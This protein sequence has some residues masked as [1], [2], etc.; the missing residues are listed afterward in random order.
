MRELISHLRI[1][2]S[3]CACYYFV[4]GC[5][6][7]VSMSTVQLHGDEEA[8]ECWDD[9]GDLQIDDAQICTV[10]TASSVANSSLRPSGHRDSISSRRSAR[11]E[12]DSITGT[13]DDWHVMLH[14]DDKFAAEEVLTSARNAGVPIPENVPKS[15]LTGGTIKRLGRR[16]ITD[17]VHD[18]AEDLVFPEKK[19]EL[20]ASEGRT[21]PDAF[22]DAF[23]DLPPSANSSEKARP[24]VDGDGDGGRPPK[25]L[26]TLDRFREDADESLQDVPTIKGAKSA[27][28]SKF[29]AVSSSAAGILPP[30]IGDDLDGFD[31]DFELP[32]DGIPLQLA[33]TKEV[34]ENHN[35]GAE[36]RA[37]ELEMEY[38]EGSIGVSFGGTARDR[39]SIPSSSISVFSP[40]TSSCITGESEDDG[41]DGLIIPDA[42]L[43][44]E[45]SLKKRQGNGFAE[46]EPQPLTPPP[47]ER[48][49]S[50]EPLAEGGDF[51]SG[52]EIG[53]MG[54][55][56]PGKL[57]VNPNVKC[58]TERRSGPSHRPSASIIF[59]DSSKMRAPRQSG[60]DRSHGTQLETVAEGGAPMSSF[61][62]PG[63]R[64]GTQSS[65]SSTSH[66]SA[67]ATTIAPAQHFRQQGMGTGEDRD[68]NAPGGVQP[69]NPRRSIPMLRNVNQLSSTPSSPRQLPPAQTSPARPKTQGDR[70]GNESALGRRSR[71]PPAA[72]IPAGPSW[73]QA[74]QH[75]NV[76]AYHS[77]RTNSDGSV[78]GLG[79]QDSLSKNSRFNRGGSNGAGANP[80]NISSTVAKRSLTKPTRRRNFGD[81]SELELFDDLPTSSVAEG[82]Y[83]KNPVAKGVPRSFRGKLNRDRAVPS[84]AEGPAQ[85]TIPGTP[86]KTQGLTPRFARDTTASRNAREQRI[87]IMPPGSRTGP[88][89]PLSTNWK[90]QPLPRN[91]R[92]SMPAK[93]GNRPRLIKPS[94]S[95]AHETKGKCSVLLLFGNDWPELY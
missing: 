87:G 47:A 62:R 84:R 93:H 7:D 57:S 63:S 20:Q 95:G 60:H 94:G 17:F 49:E 85:P 13:D 70:S 36:G 92:N 39:Q 32:T 59:T 89:A 50:H 52:I 2:D 48:S 65:N 46:P 77:R 72:F 5:P 10:S 34:F 3:T 79:L 68:S 14:G 23:A 9:D 82:K 6:L 30:D 21:F 22:P 56:D 73:S 15:A 24:S 69:L 80:G 86:S 27:S 55:N 12:L 26:G 81:G 31:E 45:S 43:D 8:I 29:A 16:R 61:H 41:L 4:Y 40:S 1:L 37:E 54:V 71:Q 67:A 19:L 53:D 75:V 76:K 18:W 83:V 11:S 90:S 44:L 33:S 88:L 58:K 28:P 66:F 25:A 78:E 64:I 38:S 74:H 42:P 51:F 91:P 35:P